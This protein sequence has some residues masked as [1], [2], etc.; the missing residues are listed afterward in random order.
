MAILAVTVLRVSGVVTRRYFA[1]MTSERGQRT[2]RRRLTAIR[3]RLPRA[4]NASHSVNTT[5][6]ALPRVEASAETQRPIDTNAAASTTVKSSSM[7]AQM[8][9][10]RCRMRRRATAAPL[11]WALP[12]AGGFPMTVKYAINVP[13]FGEFAD[14]VDFK[15]RARLGFDF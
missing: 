5:L 8:R 3:P 2:F 9:K 1:G 7:A 15:I 10:A 13:N 4:R 11:S 14:G 6:V 12:T